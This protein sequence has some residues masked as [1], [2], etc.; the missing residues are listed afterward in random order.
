M[1]TVQWS[2]PH[3][4]VAVLTC[5]VA[6]LLLGLAMASQYADWSALYG[7]TLV[8]AAILGFWLHRRARWD[9]RS[10]LGPVEFAGLEVWIALAV[11]LTW[12]AAASTALVLGPRPPTWLGI[13]FTL[14]AWVPLAI[15]GFHTWVAWGIIVQGDTLDGNQDPERYARTWLD[16][17]TWIPDRLTLDRGSIVRSVRA[18]LMSDD[19]EPT[20]DA[21]A[22]L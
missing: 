16:R 14:T 7:A 1:S 10:R 6:G 4:G 19:P 8:T 22:A 3:L 13:G 18:P 2:T 9:G 11:G 21:E 17:R 12:T 20:P 5:A 15:V